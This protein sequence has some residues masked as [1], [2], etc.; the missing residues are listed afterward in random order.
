V[1][2]TDRSVEEKGAISETDDK[3]FL[4]TIFVILKKSGGHRPI[5][6]LEPL[7]KFVHAPHF[8]MENIDT[9]RFT[10]RQ[11]DWCAII[12]LKDA[13][14]TVPIWKGHQKFLQFIWK[15]KTFQFTCLPFGLSA[16]PWA[17]TKILKVPAAHLR[18]NGIRIVI[19]LDDMLILGASQDGASLAVNAVISLL[20]GL[21][22]VINEKKSEPVP[23]QSVEF[24]GIG[25]DSIK[26]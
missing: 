9:V 2:V 25:I 21:G 4:S 18:K 3:G 5:I 6:N 24:L 14:M 13:Y 20:T 17:F 16:S 12:D 11:G 26:M 22:F 19:Y 10:I 23:A 1:T 7:N 8:K 15:G